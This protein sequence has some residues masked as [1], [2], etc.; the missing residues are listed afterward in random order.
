MG[1]EQP[2]QHAFLHVHAI[3]RLFDNHAVG[4]VE[5]FVGNL[6]APVRRQ[7]MHKHRTVGRCGHEFRVHLVGGEVATP[8]FLLALLPHAGPNVGVNRHGPRNRFPWIG[9]M[10][11]LH[12]GTL[13]VEHGEELGR[14]FVARRRG[15][16]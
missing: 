12:L 11:E 13:L 5:H 4:A 3:G 6:F 16:G 10:T 1:G 15:D 8:L 14:K 7:A 9:G 2:D